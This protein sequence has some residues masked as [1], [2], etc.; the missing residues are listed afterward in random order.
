MNESILTSVSDYYEK[1]VEEFGATP[2]GVDWNGRESQELR[3]EQLLK[4]TDHIDGAYTIDDYGCGYGELCA[5]LKAKELP[6]DYLG[7]DI[8]PKMVE[9]AKALHGEFFVEGAVSPRQA[10]VAVASGIFNVRLETEIEAW[11]VYVRETLE[12]LNERSQKGFAFNCLTSYSDKE[13]MRGDLYYADPGFYFD[14]C[15]CEFSPQVALL[16][17][18]GLYEFTIIVRKF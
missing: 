10:D 2:A 15:K 4:V 5:W 8:A 17:D 3:F 6:S 11:E 13:Y 14:L 18:Y 1:K 9:K 7:I 12:A 16:H